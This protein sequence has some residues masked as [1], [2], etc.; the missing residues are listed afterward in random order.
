MKGEKG[1]GLE[2]YLGSQVDMFWW[3]IECGRQRRVKDSSEGSDSY[4]W[5]DVGSKVVTELGEVGENPIWYR[6]GVG[7]DSESAVSISV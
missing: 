6:K 4:D 2:R 7:G 5:A 1:Y 3:P